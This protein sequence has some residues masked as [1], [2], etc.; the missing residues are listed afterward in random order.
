MFWGIINFLILRRV[1]FK[2]K[3]KSMFMC[4]YILICIVLL[5]NN[6]GINFPFSMSDDISRYIFYVQYLYDDWPE[7]ILF[8]ASTS[9]IWSWILILFKK[10]AFGSDALWL[11][12]PPFLI[13]CSNYF[14]VKTIELL[15]IK[16][17]KILLMLILFFP[18]SIFLGAVHL[19]E[20]LIIF[21]ISYLLFSLIKNKK[22]KAI[23]KF[24]NSINY[25]I[26]LFCA[27]LLFALQPAT[28]IFI[29]VFLLQFLKH[30]LVQGTIVQKLSVFIF[31]LLFSYMIVLLQ[32]G[33]GK[34][35][36]LLPDNFSTDPFRLI[37]MRLKSTDF[38]QHYSNLNLSE[39]IIVQTTSA[40]LS[41][42]T[43]ELRSTSSIFIITGL[44][45][46]ITLFFGLL[47][48]YHVKAIK[49]YFLI[50]SLLLPFCLAANSEVHAIRHILKVFPL[51]FVL[52][53][54]L[55]HKT[56]RG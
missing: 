50:L 48:M 23:K 15:D 18:T 30:R 49:L 38:L 19:K 9:W 14:I 21:L 26:Q 54:Q 53:A 56:S 37:I 24:D 42:I 39:M 47:F 46:Y 31:L 8:A 36:A 27:M 29:V 20:P 44:I 40:I 12:L 22:C 55:T 10:L 33:G 7:N 45:L 52:L 2:A 25:I 6:I 43:G 28:I 13:F 16:L 41:F 3:C 17:S 4:S 11:A 32:P 34:I 5:L 1:K 51:I 35:N